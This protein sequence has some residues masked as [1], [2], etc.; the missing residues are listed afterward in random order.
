M[1]KRSLFVTLTLLHIPRDMKTMLIRKQL[2]EDIVTE[3]FDTGFVNGSSV[4][5]IRNEEDL[6]DVWSASLPEE[7]HCS[8]V[9]IRS[10]M[11]P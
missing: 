10:G 6:S 4:I 1:G 9:H 3:N 2:S 8:L 11:V 7:Q 5:R